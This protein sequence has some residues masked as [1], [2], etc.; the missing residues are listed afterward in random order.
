MKHFV[1]ASLLALGL[2]FW[3]AHNADAKS[4]PKGA[5]VG[6]QVEV[7]A[8]VETVDMKDRHVLLRGEDGNLATITVGPEVRNLGQ[9]KP[10]DHVIFRVRL[11]VVAQMASPDASSAPVTQADIAGRTPEGARPGGLVGT[12]TRVRVTLNSYDAKSKK[13]V[14]TLPSGEQETTVIRT[15]QMQDFAAGLKSGDKVDLTFLRSVA[16]AVVPAT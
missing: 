4:A 16:V 6:A 2:V 11:G 12:A 5:A 3:S 14:F 15:K 9:V 10:G 1:T 7:K 8:T 13:V